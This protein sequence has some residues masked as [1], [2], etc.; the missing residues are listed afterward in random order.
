V[1]VATP[2]AVSV[3]VVAPTLEVLVADVGAR[4]LP[5][6]LAVCPGHPS[7]T[8]GQGVS[9]C[10]PSR[11]S[12]PP[13]SLVLL[14]SGLPGLPSLARGVGSGNSGAVLQHHGPD[15]AGWYRVDR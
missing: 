1:V 5:L 6:P 9:P 10:G 15:S 3:V 7:P 14:R 4:C 13:C 2:V 8:H 12:R 11:V